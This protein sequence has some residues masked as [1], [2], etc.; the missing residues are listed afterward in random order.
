MFGDKRED[1]L[2]I[3]P[4]TNHTQ[5][6]DATI[7]EKDACFEGK[8]TFEGDV[9]INGKLK[10]EVHSTGD[11]TVGISG[12]IEGK[13]EIGTIHIRGTVRG[14]ISAK[15][16]II[17]HANAALYGDV[18]TPSLVVED[19]AVFEGGCVMSKNNDHKESSSSHL[20]T[21]ADQKLKKEEEGFLHA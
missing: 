15:T 4:T 8:L 5:H 9:S 21:F 12:S 2:Q 13:I 10:G 11:L 19:G 16:K 6:N 20:K 7:I 18:S 14:T 17:I 1:S 3:V